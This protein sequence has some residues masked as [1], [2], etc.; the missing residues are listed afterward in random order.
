MIITHFRTALRQVMKHID[1]TSN[2]IVVHFGPPA[3]S[4]AVRVENGRVWITAHDI[5][6]I[7]VMDENRVKW[8]K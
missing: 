4:G 2:Q 5:N 7:W 6:T 3:G 1:P 8:R